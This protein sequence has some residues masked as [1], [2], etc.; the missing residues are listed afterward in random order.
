LLLLGREVAVGVTIGF[1]ASCVFRAAEAAG[2]L[3]DTLRG[4]NLAEV[5]SPNAEGQ[6]SP[7]GDVMLLLATV[8]FLE[9]GG[10]GQLATALARSYEAVP[11][12]LA[13]PAAGLGAAAQLVVL[14]S[15][16]L[17]EGAVALAAPAIVALL[18]ADIALGAIARLGPPIPIHLTGLPLKAL[19][20]VGVALVG[21][22]GLQAALT[23]AFRGWTELIERAAS[24][25]R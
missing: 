5:I 9:L 4:P 24:V 8:I 15:A 25:W 12:T 11:L 19:A 6:A 1:V 13:A 21:L 2:R 20:G 17:L 10:T 16:R 7:F 23:G 18:L 14:A 3:V 22:G